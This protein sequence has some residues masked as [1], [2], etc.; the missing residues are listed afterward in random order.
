MRPARSHLARLALALPL[1]CAAGLAGAQ[2]A[3]NTIP[4]RDVTITYK[5]MGGQEMTISWLAADK[6]MRMDLPGGAGIMLLDAKNQKGYMVMEAQRAV[7]ELPV[8]NMMGQI[9]Q[10]PEGAKLTRQGND[11]VAGQSCTVWRTEYMGQIGNSC[12]SADGVL[13]RAR[14]EGSPEGLEATQVSFARQDPA[15]FTVPADYQK[16]QMPGR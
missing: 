16:M 5:A 14:P 10:V 11:T 7:M 1:V 15:R 9:G 13:L 8:E 2:T 3:P 12:I 4:T 6:R